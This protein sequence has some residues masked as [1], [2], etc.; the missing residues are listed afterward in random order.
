MKIK[1][2][3]QNKSILKNLEIERNT[4]EIFEKL[5][6][7]LGVEI[8]TMANFMITKGIISFLEGTEDKDTFSED[9]RLHIYGM[10]SYLK[11]NLLDEV[12]RNAL[13]KL[14]EGMFE[15]LNKE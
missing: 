3:E 10:D 13:K 2:D 15:V 11:I 7:H 4:H 1:I 6:K 9:E 5:C 12:R 14:I 8:Y